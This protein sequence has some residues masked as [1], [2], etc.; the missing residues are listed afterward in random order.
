MARGARLIDAWRKGDAGRAQG[1]VRPGTRATIRSRRSPTLIADE[2]RLLC[3]DELQV[4]DI[5]DAMILGRLFEALFARGVTLVA[6]SNRPPDDLYKNGIN[7]QLFLPF[8]AMLKEP[9]RGGRR[10]GPDG[11]P[12]RP[13]ARRAGS[14]CR[15]IDARQPRRRSTPCGR[16]MLDG[17]AETGRDPGGAGPQDAPAARRRR[18]GARLLRQPVRPGAGAAGLSG[19][20]RALPHR[21]PR[22]RAR[23][24]TPDK[25]AARPSGSSP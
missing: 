9:A 10:G 20:R 22:G 15:P 24:S 25:R 1:A 8:I 5:A 6:T 17:A 23:C 4:T 19:H 18:P 3:F 2:A 14:G 16:D 12:A 21:L 11:L 13:A 7:R